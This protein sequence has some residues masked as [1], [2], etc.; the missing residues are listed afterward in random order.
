MSQSG[1]PAA[2]AVAA[3]LLLKLWLRV[4]LLAVAC[5]LQAVACVL[6]KATNGVCELLSV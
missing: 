1:M 6:Q 5:V 4:V 3:A 2:A